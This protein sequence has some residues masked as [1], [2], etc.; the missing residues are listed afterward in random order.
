VTLSPQQ[1]FPLLAGLFLLA[2]VYEILRRD[3]RRGRIR[4]WLLLAMSFGA[5]S[6]WMRWH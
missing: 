4:A 6:A 1:I 3:S 5:V 2:T